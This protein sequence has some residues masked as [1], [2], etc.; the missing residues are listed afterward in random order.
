VTA[1]STLRGIV[2][3]M[4]INDCCAAKVLHRRMELNLAALWSLCAPDPQQGG[5]LLGMF[6]AGL[7]GSALHCAPMCGAFVLGQVADGMAA[8]PQAKLCEWRRLRAGLLL[9]YH[10]GRLTTYAGLGAIGAGSAAV[11][12]HAPWFSHLSAALL[13]VASL[14]F[15]THALARFLPG[16]FAVVPAVWTRGI[17][18]LSGGID[19]RGPGG[20]Y[21]LG[22]ALGLLPCAFLY[23]ALVAA[24]SASGPAQGA[25]AMLAFGLGT[26]PGLV[27]VG[28]AGQALGHRW[29]RCVTMAGPGLMAVNAA[30]LFAVAL[31]R[32]S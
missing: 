4:W 15:L 2:T 9:P 10:F 21:L 19:T 11:L 18:R 22:L 14:M 28:V 23:G 13:M 30:V 6:L 26:V 29:K 8:I 24:A 5:L 7:V 25:A 32:M 12:A 31:Q 17:A 16:R 27:V 1:A 3:L 20:G